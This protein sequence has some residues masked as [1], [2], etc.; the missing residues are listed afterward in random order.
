MARSLEE[1]EEGI[2]LDRVSGARMANVARVYSW[3]IARDCIS[4]S[5]LKVGI[6][7]IDR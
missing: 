4:I 7:F 2:E 5:I 6:S 3:W 1:V